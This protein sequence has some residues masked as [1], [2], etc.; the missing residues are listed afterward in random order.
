MLP[1]FFLNLLVDIV[2][3]Q[4]KKKLCVTVIE[5]QNAIELNRGELKSLFN[6]LPFSR[7]SGT[8]DVMMHYSYKM[9]S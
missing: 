3:C 4:I 7:H 6:I 2:Q 1:L 5:D 9:T 8:K